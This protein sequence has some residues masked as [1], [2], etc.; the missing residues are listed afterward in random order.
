MY[1]IKIHNFEKQYLLDEMIRVFLSS[2]SYRIL[3]D[4]EDN[5]SD[6]VVH[7]NLSGSG[8]KNE[9][10][11]EIYRT[12]STLTSYEPEWGILTGI[13]PVKLWGETFEELGNRIQT[14]ELMKDKFLLSE[15]K[16][17]LV[18][19]VYN[20]QKSMIGGIDPNNSSVYIGI[21][22]CPT[23][24]SYCSFASNQVPESEIALYFFALL[25]EIKEVGEM[26]KEYKMS[27][28]SIYIGGG[29]PTTLNPSQIAELLCTIKETIP[30][31][32]VKEITLEAGRPDTITYE[33]LQAAIRDGVN[34][35]SINPQT[36]NDDTLKL[37]GRNHDTNMVMKAFEIAKSFSFDAVN[38]DIIAG[39]PGEDLEDF[40]HT[41]YE[42]LGL[43][44]NNITI[45]SLA[46]K[47]GS[48]LIDIDRDYYHKVGK[49]VG[50]MLEFGRDVLGE[51]GYRPY[52]LYRQKHM[53]GANENTGYC[54]DDTFCIYN[55]AIMDEHED[56]V[57]LGAGGISKAFFPEE[58]RLE[59]I[60]NVTN[61]QEYISRVDEM[62]ERKKIGFAN[63]RFNNAD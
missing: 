24:C 34:R 20:Y 7:F 51:N 32:R 12:L 23:R 61:Y 57:A 52:Y 53:A 10:K 2:D 44:P 16:L 43:S 62:I 47:R 3:S 42:V 9:I 35:I 29:T 22:F 17:E 56:I 60:P 14:R 18:E 54:K 58:N 6:E 46:V 30:M 25:R 41:I 45:H 11:R 50:E 1:K 27:P 4:E 36:M 48:K 21:P 40:K 63:R 49:L 55:M 59:R 5:L 38:C 37:I 39:L 28:R 26:M 19:D 13:R 15:D 8:D 31:S 33:K